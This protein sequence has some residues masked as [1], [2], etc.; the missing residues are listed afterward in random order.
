MRVVSHLLKIKSFNSHFGYKSNWR[1]KA[2]RVAGQPQEELYGREAICRQKNGVRETRQAIRK[3]TL[4]NIDQKLPM[5]A[6]Q[7]PMAD[8]MNKI[9]P[10][11]LI[12][13]FDII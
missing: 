4:P 10:I 13:L 8:K 6:M 9:Q 1:A 11:R 3:N 12:M 7:K 5:L 2:M